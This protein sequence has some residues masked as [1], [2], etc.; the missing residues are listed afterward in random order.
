[1]AAHRTIFVRLFLAYL[2]YLFEGA[3]E[4]SPRLTV[5]FACGLLFPSLIG[6]IQ[7][8]DSPRG[9]PSGAPANVR[10]V[11]KPQRG[12]LSSRGVTSAHACRRAEQR[13]CTL[14]LKTATP[15]RWSSCWPRAPTRTRPTRY[16]ARRRVAACA[17]A[18]CGYRA[19]VDANTVDT[20]HGR[21]AH[22][23]LHVSPLSFLPFATQNYKA[24]M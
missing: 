7:P 24:V 8:N 14:R 6:G 16:G 21:D 11:G 15:R 18:A 1:M 10:I 5:I 20:A 9:L 13:P 17:G 19:V 2:R 12:L 4:T 23:G 3:S 22:W